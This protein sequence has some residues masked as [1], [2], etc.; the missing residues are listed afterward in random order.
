[1]WDPTAYK[2]FLAILTGLGNS[3][4]FFLS[5]IKAVFMENK[6]YNDLWCAAEG[7]HDAAA[8]LYAIL[9]YRDNGVATAADTAK[10]YMSVTPQVFN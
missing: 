10:R 1:V 2:A 5:G 7:G 6:G 3:G 9:F 8:Y 4:A